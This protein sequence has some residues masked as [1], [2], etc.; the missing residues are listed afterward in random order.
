MNAVRIPRFGD[1][2]VLE[3]VQ[4]PEP[5]PGPG[6]VRVAVRYAGINPGEIPI[7]EGRFGGEPPFGQ[8]SDFAGEIVGLGEGVT[9][10]RIGSDVIGMSDQRSAQADYVVLPADRVIP[11]PAGLGWDVAGAL[12][13]AATTAVA[14]VDTIAPHPGDRVV[15][16]GAAGGV[17]VLAAQL[18]ARAGARVIGTA[19]EQNHEALRG[20]GIE[21]VAYGDGAQGRIRLLATDGVDAFIDT[22]GRG[23]VDLALDLGVDPGRIETIADFAAASRGCTPSGCR[24]SPT[25]EPPSRSWRS[26]SRR[27]RSR[28][29]SRPG[30]R[31]TTSRRP[32]TGSRSGTASA[33]S[34]CRSAPA[35][36]PDGAA[37]LLEVAGADR[38]PIDVSPSDCPRAGRIGWRHAHRIRA[39]VALAS[40]T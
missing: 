24:R 16:A 7:R 35:S 11:K 6:E 1:S 39:E 27:A 30:T 33:R 31:S 4:V 34:C 37:V 29:R 23:N 25:R 2:S 9:G 22:H 18:A 36:D 13:V 3:L 20:L 12:Y 15:V 32:T 19:S 28:C 40:H 21:P 8:G 14:A 5:E 38:D 17:G 10:W 26:S